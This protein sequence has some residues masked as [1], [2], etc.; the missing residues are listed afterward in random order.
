MKTIAWLFDLY[1]MGDRLVLWF[2]TQEGE[3]LRLTAAFPYTVYVGGNRDQVRREVQALERRKWFTRTYPTRGRDLGSGEEMPV[4]AMDLKTYAHLPQLRDWLGKKEGI[5]AAYNCDLDV[6]A[7][8]L[9]RKGIWPSAWYD[10]E[11]REG[12]LLAL[13]PREDQFARDVSLPPLATLGLGLTKDPLIPL[14]AGNSLAVTWEGRTLELEAADQTGLVREVAGLLRKVNPDLVLSDWGD[15]DIIPLLWRWS[16]DARLPLPLDR[17]TGVIPRQ[18]SGGRSYFSYGR[19]VYQGSAAP[20]YGRWHVDRRNS[21]FFREADLMGL[22]QISRLGQLPLQQAARAS[23]GTLIT[24]MQLARAV[25]DGILIPWRKADPERFKSAGELL[26]VDKG[27]LVFMPPI[28]LY[29][30]VGELDFA[31]MYPSIMAIHNISPETVNCKCCVGEGASNYVGEGAQGR[32]TLPPHPLPQSLSTVGR[33]SIPSKHGQDARATGQTR[34]HGRP[35]CGT[36]KMPVLPDQYLGGEEAGRGGITPPLRPWP[37]PHDQLVPEAGY[38]LCRRR[39]GLVPRTLRPILALRES[40]K[41]A[42][43]ESAPDMAVLYNQR[44][45]ALKWMLVTCFGYLGYKNA[46][47]GRIEAHEAVTAFG[48][49]KLL[50]AKEICEDKGYEVLHGLTDCLWIHRGDMTEAELEALCREVSG[51]TGVKLALEGVYRWLAFLPSRQNPE[52]PV[53]TR[54][55]GVFADGQVKA[56]GLIC[57]RRDTPPFVRRAQEALLSRL[58]A[59]ATRGDLLSLAPELEEMA[60]GFRQRLREGGIPPPELVITRVLSQPL[61]NYKVETPTALALRQLQQAGVAVR[62]GEKVRFVHREGRGPKECRVQAAPFLEGLEGYDTMLYLELL[63]R[64]VAEVMTGVFGKAWTGNALRGL[65]AAKSGP[66]GG[67]S[68]LWRPRRKGD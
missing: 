14:G 16:K 17:E 61:E 11:A 22:V 6:A 29:F 50:T 5:L 55:F 21:F 68:S 39:E 3:A 59:A 19:V 46:R 64:A 62:P 52:R 42:A 57:R 65:S 26:T 27:G 49:E 38:R 45:T 54:Y 44:Q 47:F 56:R 48:R 34:E 4:W 18:F 20:F 33:A 36:G 9:Y 2:L 66:V 30:N 67:R 32:R 10:L 31:S 35:A 25:A 58:A 15:E 53:A 28:G 13:A 60:E 23:P 43:R 41:A 63:E 7:Y 8:Y 37:S 51:A 12:R 40:L 24:S 1:P